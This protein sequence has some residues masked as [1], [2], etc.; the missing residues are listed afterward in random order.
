MKQIQQFSAILV[1]V[2]LLLVC[3]ACTKPQS[4]DKST[5]R[6]VAGI[7]AYADVVSEIGGTHVSVVTLIPPGKNPHSFDLDP[8]LMKEMNNADLAVFNGAGLEMWAESIAE[9]MRGNGVRVAWVSDILKDSLIANAEHGHGHDGHDHGAVNPHFWLDPALM[10]P[11][12]DA[13]RDSLC[14]LDPKHAAEYQA[15]A[16]RFIQKLDA[17][18]SAFRAAS[19]AWS[20]RAFVSTHA[21][22]AYF[23]RRYG[24]REAGVLETAPGTELSAKTLASMADLMKKDNLQVIFTQRLF[25]NAVA[26]ALAEETGARLA[27]LDPHGSLPGVHGYIDLMKHNFAIMD[28]AM[29]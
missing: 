20:R 29:R 24:I 5:L 3:A 1:I 18:D 26:K 10:K 21:A 17:L 27:E 13:I 8:R 14:V 6:V 7:P 11:V 19:S 16:L 28:K 4:P 15:S 2:P 22:W 25:P 9:S 12:A 23:C